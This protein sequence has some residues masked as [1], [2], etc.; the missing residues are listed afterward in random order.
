[1]EQHITTIRQANNSL[2]PTAFGGDLSSKP[3]GGQVESTTDTTGRSMPIRV[4][5][6]MCLL[7]ERMRHDGGS[8]RDRYVTDTLAEFFKWVPVC[9][10]VEVDMGTPHEAIH[11]VQ[12]SGEG[13]LVGRQSGADHAEAMRSYARRR[14]EQLASENLSGY[15]LKKDSPSCGLE[16][17]RLH[18]ADG[19][20]CDARLREKSSRSRSSPITSGVA[21]PNITKARCT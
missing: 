5:V 16:R 3:F 2:E 18:H 4:G 9:P 12:L 7:G 19:R 17:V 14:V 15:I 11:L 8:K 21:T 13:R 20:L 1:M 6:S 10:E